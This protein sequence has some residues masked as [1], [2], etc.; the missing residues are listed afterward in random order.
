M[1]DHGYVQNT[2]GRENVCLELCIDRGGAT[3]AV[4]RACV[5]G[6]GRQTDSMTFI[7]L[8]WILSEVR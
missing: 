7:Q 6:S 3:L 8:V 4:L 5:M 2:I 1:V